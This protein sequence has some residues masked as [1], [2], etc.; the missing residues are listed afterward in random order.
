MVKY[1][2]KNKTY[3]YRHQLCDCDHQLNTS[4]TLWAEL[5]V[6]GKPLVNTLSSATLPYKYHNYSTLIIIQT[7]TTTVK[8]SVEYLLEYIIFDMELTAQTISQQAIAEIGEE[9][10]P[11]WYSGQEK[12]VSGFGRRTSSEDVIFSVLVSVGYDPDVIDVRKYVLIECWGDMKRPLGHTDRVMNIWRAWGELKDRVSYIVAKRRYRRNGP[13]AQRAQQHRRRS[14]G[15]GAPASVSSTE[16]GYCSQSDGTSSSSEPLSVSANIEEGMNDLKNL[17]SVIRDQKRAIRRQAE[18]LRELNNIAY[19]YEEQLRSVDTSCQSSAAHKATDGLDAT[20]N[21]TYENINSSVGNT[22]SF[23]SKSSRRVCIDEAQNVTHVIESCKDTTQHRRRSGAINIGKRIQ[24][25]CRPFLACVRKPK[26]V[27][28]IEDSFY[29][30]CAND[31]SS[32]D[33]MSTITT[34]NTTLNQSNNSV[35]LPRCEEENEV[36]ESASLLTQTS[37]RSISHPQN[38]SLLSDTFTSSMV[39]LSST[40]NFEKYKL[41]ENSPACRPVSTHPHYENLSTISR[42]RNISPSTKS[43]DTYETAASTVCTDGT[44]CQVA[45]RRSLR[46]TASDLGC[47]YDSGC[48]SVDNMSD[49]G[50]HPSNPTT[51][52]HTNV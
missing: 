51:N 28:D 32:S 6:T 52:K 42:T 49:V 4:M 23:S 14:C 44:R 37:L 47:T 1:F 48:G 9:E 26:T 17:N 21:H 50:K 45:Q 18:H 41:P 31:V 10:L 16:D 33:A 36:L 40:I 39:S 19:H 5:F 13:A 29:K 38:R 7:L 35:S 43:H 25:T 20:V 22:S 3:L 24:R 27:E 30:N 46:S 8:T 2:G 15:P 11:V 34:N 12:R